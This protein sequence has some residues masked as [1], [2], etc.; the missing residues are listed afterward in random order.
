MP[1]MF[2]TTRSSP[3][4]EPGCSVSDT[5]WYYLLI[6][7]SSNCDFFSSQTD[8]QTDTRWWPVSKFALESVSAA[9]CSFTKIRRCYFMGIKLYKGIPEV[10]TTP[11][12]SWTKAWLTASLKV[13]LSYSK[14]ALARTE[15]LPANTSTYFSAPTT[16]NTAAFS[17]QMG[18]WSPNLPTSILGRGTWQHNAPPPA[19]MLTDSPW[20]ELTSFT[21]TAL[22]S[23][24]TDFFG[25]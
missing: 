13:N 25:A 14:P 8:R 5:E 24:L 18:I 9:N 16:S 19:T 10:Y 1:T 20:D 21:T 6:R 23:K 11:T 15:V 4:I 12:K 7:R 3:G 22:S 2:T 17:L